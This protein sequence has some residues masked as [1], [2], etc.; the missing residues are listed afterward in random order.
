MAEL[1]LNNLKVSK[2]SNH[3]SKRLG[4]GNASGKGT[5]SARGLKG[6]RARSGGRGGS[7][8]RGLSQLLRNKPKLGGFKSLQPKPEVVNVEDLQKHFAD[9][10]LVN[11]KNLLA[12]KLIK[13]IKPGVKILGQGKLTKK[14]T[15]KANSFSESAKKVI[16][17]AGGSVQLITKVKKSSK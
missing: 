15:V 1:S 17:E 9:G 7:K 12:K 14:L 4:R 6:Q 10:E 8:R 11:P 5:Y 13:T 3:K 2:G 16:M